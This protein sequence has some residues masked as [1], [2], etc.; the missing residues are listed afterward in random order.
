MTLYSYYYEEWVSKI[1]P[2]LITYK[3]LPNLVTDRESK[4]PIINNSN[5]NGPP[6]KFIMC[7][8]KKEYRG[9]NR[10]VLGDHKHF[11]ESF[12]LL[13]TQTFTVTPYPFVLTTTST[14]RSSTR[15][16]VLSS[17][18]VNSGCDHSRP[19]KFVDQRVRRGP[20]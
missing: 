1:T 18:R 8:I 5:F 10:R 11:K 14:G 19:L 7:G 6:W 13:F 3:S 16:L 9:L 4:L 2:N 12:R 20:G 15:Q 17:P